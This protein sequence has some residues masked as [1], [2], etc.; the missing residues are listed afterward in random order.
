M[1]NVLKGISA[2][3]NKTKVKNKKLHLQ[4]IELITNM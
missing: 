4:L 3:Q 2:G 1:V